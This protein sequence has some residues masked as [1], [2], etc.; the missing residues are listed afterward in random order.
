MPLYL[1]VGTKNGAGDFLDRNGLKNGQLYAWKATATGVNSPA[2]FVSGTQ[3]GT[4]VP[5]NARNAANAGTTGYDALGYKNA[6]TLR[7]EADAAGAFSFSRPEDLAT[8]PS[9]PLQIVFASTGASISAGNTADSTADATDVWGTIY[10]ATLSFTNLELPNGLAD[11]GLQRQYRC[12]SR[13]A[14]PG[15]P[16][17]G[18]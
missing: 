2:E 11:G 17:L 12:D 10:T 4:W 14:Q 5:I 13:L 3:A 16:G 15:Q 6:T 7:T 18:P 9:N 8:N 1:Y